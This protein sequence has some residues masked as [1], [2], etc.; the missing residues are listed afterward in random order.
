[1][2]LVSR[3]WMLDAHELHRE[4]DEL[5]R[6][7]RAA[8][9]LQG[10][11]ERADAVWFSADPIARTY[12][13]VLRVAPPDEW[14]PSTSTAQLGDWYRVVM[15]EH[16]TPTRAIRAPDLVKRRLPEL[17]WSPAEA[18]RLANGRELQSLVDTYGDQRLFPSI[19]PDLTLADRGWL[20][21]DDVALGLDRLRT[22]DPRLFR[23]HQDIVGV[24]EQVYEV[25]EAAATK[26][27]LVLLV[28]VD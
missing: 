22:L 15:A 6:D 9:D 4:I 2:T 5:L 16:L 13:E 7:A 25:L 18:R 20:S 14:V 8:G 17:G 26:P 1:V 10:L 27:D 24:V 11:R 3:A 19:A 12:L 28:I 23:H 21:Q